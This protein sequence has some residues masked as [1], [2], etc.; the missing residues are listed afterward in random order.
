MISKWNPLLAIGFAV[1]LLL[2]GCSGFVTEV[3]ADA[4]VSSA[5]TVVIDGEPVVEFKYETSEDA[6]ALLETPDGDV[7]DTVGLSSDD[8]SAQLE[9]DDRSGGTYSIVIEVDGESI[10]RQNVTLNESDT[11]IASTTANWSNNR[12]QQVTTTVR[13][14]GDMPAYVENAELS[15][16]GTT[17]NSNTGGIWLESGGSRTV[18]I[19]PG[20]REVTITESGDVRGAVSVSTRDQNV[21][22]TIIKR[23]AGANLTVQNVSAHWDDLLLNEVAVTVSNTGDLPTSANLSVFESGGNLATNAGERVGI[24]DTTT[25]TVTDSFGIYEQT[26]AGTVELS[27]VVDSSDGFTERTISHTAAGGN[28]TLVSMNPVWQNGKLQNVELTVENDGDLPA[29]ISPTASVAGEQFDVRPDGIVVFG[30]GWEL[31]A[32]ETATYDLGDEYG[33]NY[34]T[35]TAG[36]DVPVTVTVAEQSQSETISFAG[37]ELEISGAD[38]LFLSNYGTD[39]VDLSSLSMTVENNGDVPI[40][41]DTVEASIDGSTVSDESSLTTTVDPGASEYKTTNF[42]TDITVSTGQHEM[43]I[44]LILDGE[45]V[46]SDTITV[47]AQ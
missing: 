29:T 26:S 14:D 40:Q 38:P 4:S 43:T 5:Q 2:S 28:V 6:K 36:G 1:L 7:A 16:R 33:E 13:N 10:Q 35:P 11:Q 22:T 42:L 19:S 46:A 47:T 39:T 24:N 31:E 30:D 9:L 34:Y 37:P 45:T 3:T 44:S 41:Y 20:Y 15:V 12:L 21:S 25:L 8:S 18:S 23:F 32:G 27:V 17:V